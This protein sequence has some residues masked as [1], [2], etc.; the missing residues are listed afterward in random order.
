MS[1]VPCLDKIL[2]EKTNKQ[3]R[4]KIDKTDGHIITIHYPTSF[5]ASYLLDFIKLEIGPRASRTPQNEI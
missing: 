4:F 5:S 3:V 1:I 2:K